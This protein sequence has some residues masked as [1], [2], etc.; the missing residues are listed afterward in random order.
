MIYRR[1]QFTENQRESDQNHKKFLSRVVFF[2]QP[3]DPCL[4]SFRKC[5]RMTP[6]KCLE[7][8]LFLIPRRHHF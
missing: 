4:K 6:R 3:Q 7:G 1:L 5:W 2:R 8:A